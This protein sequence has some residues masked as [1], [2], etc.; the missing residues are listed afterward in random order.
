MAEPEQAPDADPVGTEIASIESAMADNHGAYWEGPQAEPM[1][2]RYRQLLEARAASPASAAERGRGAVTPSAA[3][4]AASE[5]DNRALA[6][7]YSLPV[8]TIVVARDVVNRDD[9]RS[10]FTDL[11]VSVIDGLTGGLQSKMVAHLGMPFTD[12]P[13]DADSELQRDFARTAHGKILTERWGVQTPRRLAIGNAKIERFEA[14]LTDEEFSEWRRFW[15]GLSPT[16]K[17]DLVD[18]GTR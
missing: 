16:E 3:P 4:A 6:E 14:G 10:I 11:T 13:S 7:A 1:Q 2:A 5:A 8:D 18:R 9:G 12:R 17:A 15:N